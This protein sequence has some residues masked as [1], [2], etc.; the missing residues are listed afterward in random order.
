V[1]SVKRIRVDEAP[2]ASRLGRG[3]FA[4]SDDYSVF[5]WGR[6]PDSIPG[7]GAALCVTG[8]HSFALLEDAGIPTHY[9]GVVHGGEA[10]PLEAALSAG[11]APDEM[12]IELAD[13]PDLPTTGAGY[14]YD[15]YH[16]AAG[17]GYL[18]PLEVVF[19]NHVPVGSS[20]R[21]RTDPGAHGLAFEEWPEETVALPEPVV[22]FSTKFEHQDRYLDRDEADAIAGAA[23]IDELAS[24]ARA[25]NRVVTE[26]AA[27]AGLA[28][29]DGKIECLFDGG[30]IRV[31][32]VV[33]TFD[34]NRFA[35]DGR[36]VSK[37]LLR[38]HH[39]HTQS[40]WVAAVR[41][42]KALAEAEGTPEW[43]SLCDPAPAPLA[44][45]VVAHVGRLYRAGA[46]AYLD[47]SVFAVPDLDALLE[48]TPELLA[49][50]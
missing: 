27:A 36:Q 26:R 23:P 43:R 1:T 21:R 8:A 46:N 39:T 32:D 20:L 7:K 50:D 16:A 19:R 11:A 6:M 42:A 22:E 35:R 48:R 24:V 15:A 41:E 28:H 18:I 25:V 47:R 4:F 33:G 17:E 49:L 13:V 38:Q 34:E 9:R 29:L 3:R 44:G 12:A 30:E 40:E 37:E 31:A 10:Q 2:T 5:D 14:D 45:P